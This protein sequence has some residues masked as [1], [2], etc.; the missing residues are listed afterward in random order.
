[1]KAYGFL[2]TIYKCNYF[3]YTQILTVVLSTK[4]KNSVSCAGIHLT[5]AARKNFKLSPNQ[6]SCYMSAE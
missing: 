4:K 5:L 2:M 1:M 6:K 3:L